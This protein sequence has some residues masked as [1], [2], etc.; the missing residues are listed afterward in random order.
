M[1]DIKR[2]KDELSS[3]HWFFKFEDQNELPE[4]VCAA[5]KKYLPHVVPQSWDDRL[6]WGGVYLNGRTCSA[7]KALPCPCVVEY[8]EPKY[9][10]GERW[11]FY[12]HFSED[13]I[14]FEDDDILVVF[15]PAGLPCLPSR[16]QHHAHLKSYLEHHT[17]KRIHM[18]SRL[19][20]SVSGLIITSKSATMHKLLQRSF[21]YRRVSKHYLFESA[22]Q[23]D[24]AEKEVDAPIGKDEAHP[25]LRKVSFADGRPAK[26]FFK[27]VCQSSIAEPGRQTKLS[28]LIEAK[29]FSGR[30]HQLRIHSS[31]IGA[32][33]VG[34]GFYGGHPHR[35]LRLLSFKISLF[36]PNKNEEFTFV[37][38][39]RFWPIWARKALELLLPKEEIS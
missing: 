18:P 1:P 35:G 7:D 27:F 25:I 28:S 26:T 8:F 24:W 23:V 6:I 16:E 38:P 17:K 3:T 31:H 13:M 9:P 10:F 5:L 20:T 34:D 14:V 11:N 30:T 33:I 39:Y 22:V 2:L 15:K 37:L 32:P 12:P 29:P 4:S 21:E 19:D 36:V